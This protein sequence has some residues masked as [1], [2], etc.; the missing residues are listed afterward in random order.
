MNPNGEK[1]TSCAFVILLLDL[2]RHRFLKPRSA[3]CFHQ[4]KS[5]F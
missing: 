1:R 4:R 5:S 2:R 3:G